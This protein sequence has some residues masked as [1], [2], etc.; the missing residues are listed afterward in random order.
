M[1]QEY[2][3]YMDYLSKAYN[4]EPIDKIKLNPEKL[5]Y[6]HNNSD[7]DCLSYMY[8]FCEGE[9][10]KLCERMITLNNE[11]TIGWGSELAT[12]EERM[13]YDDGKWKLLNHFGIGNNLGE[14]Y[15][16]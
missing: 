5:A 3:E 8:P 9:W 15:A 10:K 13:D 14:A 12:S 2:V 11:T 7:I 16:M 1:K 6:M 4:L